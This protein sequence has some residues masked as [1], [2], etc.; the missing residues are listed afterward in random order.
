MNTVLWQVTTS[1]EAIALY[2]KQAW[3]LRHPLAH[4]DQFTHFGGIIMSTRTRN[5]ASIGY[6]ESLKPNFVSILESYHVEAF[7]SPLH[8]KDIDTKNEEGTHFKKP[9]YHIVILF[10]GCRKKEEAQAI[11][12]SIGAVGV[13]KI[14]NIK[15]YC[16]YLCH[17]DCKEPE[18]FHYNVQDVIS[19]SGADYTAMISRSTDKYTAIGEMLE[20]CIDSDINSYATLILYARD[21]R[22]DW[23]ERL[24]DGA[25]PVILSFL[26]SRT[27]ESQQCIEHKHKNDTLISK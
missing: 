26:R 27:W 24:C 12:S 9:H 1:N 14:I 11:F 5:Y 6:L 13:E 17:L 7:I 10:Q 3:A 4:K 16:R 21:H 15:S 22:R 8:D 2:Q 25:T 18:K 20:F 19:L 23:F